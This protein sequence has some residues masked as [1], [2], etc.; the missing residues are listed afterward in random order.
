MKKLIYSSPEVEV[1]E[2]MLEKGFA[3]SETDST[4]PINDWYYDSF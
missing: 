4:N 3:A 1:I 2:V